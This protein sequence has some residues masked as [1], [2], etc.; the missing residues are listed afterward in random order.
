MADRFANLSI[1]T[2]TVARMDVTDAS[3]PAELNMLVG[4]L[5]LVLLV[6][7]AEKRAPWQFYSGVGKIGPIMKWVQ[8]FASFPFELPELPHLK[9]SDRI[10]YKQQIR[11]REEGLAEKRE[12]EAAE[13]AEEERKQREFFERRKQQKEEKVE[14]EDKGKHQHVVDEED[15][16]L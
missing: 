9:E 4:P 6:P 12:K 2:L 5:P 1:P 15:L 13:M 10:L 16:E 11:E 8:K 7:A 3:P 14:V